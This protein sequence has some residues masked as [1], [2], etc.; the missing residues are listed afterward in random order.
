MIDLHQ[1]GWDTILH[2]FDGRS[3]EVQG[4]MTPRWPAGQLEEL[5]N[6]KL[7]RELP[8]AKNLRCLECTGGYDRDVI[9]T[10]PS[11]GNS[12][13]LFSCPECGLYEIPID[14]LR[15]WQVDQFAMRTWIR[16]SLPINGR[17]GDIVPDRLWR[18]GRWQRT[19]NTWTVWLGI[20]M[21]RRNA[22]PL[23]EA[24]L[25]PN[26]LLI[27]PWRSPRNGI[28]AGVVCSSLREITYWEKGEPDWDEDRLEELLNLRVVAQSPIKKP[29]TPKRQTRAVDIEALIA[30]LKQHLRAA[31]DHAFFSRDSTGIPVLLPRPTQKQLAQRLGISESRVSRSLNDDEAT[32][33]KLLWN[34]AD[35]L[36]GVLRYG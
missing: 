8:P 17:Q 23:L 14:S 1:D 33:L 7:L 13:V 5:L 27:S 9:V 28:P 12:R 26:S 30:E 20:G 24:H 21:C 34:L 22:Q 35:D 15:R 16:E 31:R 32:Q 19:D 4:W 25:P 2:A 10:E 6:R 18:L 11:R 36:E 29:A 3:L